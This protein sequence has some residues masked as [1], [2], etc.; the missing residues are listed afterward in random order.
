[1]TGQLALDFTGPRVRDTDPDT[2]QA[3]ADSMTGAA[4]TAQASTVL[5]TLADL[6]RRRGVG[7][8]A[9][10]LH[11]ELDGRYQ[12]SVIARRLTDL[13]DAGL[14]VDTGRRRPGSS[15]R[16]LIVWTSTGGVDR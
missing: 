3:A 10:E 12:Q 13:R 14:V 15:N 6:D 1:M 11:V 8:T 2:S 4:L 5:A 7:A 16:Q 9:Y